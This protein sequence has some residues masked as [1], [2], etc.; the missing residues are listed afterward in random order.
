MSPSLRLPGA[1]VRRH[2][3]ARHAAAA[4]AALLAALAGCGTE[5]TPPAARSYVVRGE[6]VELP[7]PGGRDLVLHHE[8]IDDLVGVDGA[9]WGMDAMVMPF[10]LAEGVGLD[11]IA[12]GDKVE[13]SLAVDWLGSQPHRITRLRRLPD[14]TPLVFRRAKPGARPPG[15]GP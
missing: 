10:T 9:I 14:D 4:A 8:A 1:A 2:R 3:R 6:V 15:D 11:G 7:P 13:V 12:R 5:P